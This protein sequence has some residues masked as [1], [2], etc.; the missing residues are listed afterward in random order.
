MLTEKQVKGLRRWSCTG[1]GTGLGYI[2]EDYLVLRERAGKV[3][4]DIRG[5]ISVKRLCS[6][7]GTENELNQVTSFRSR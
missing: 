7:C 4:L 2:G 6:N 3:T 5:A 1:C